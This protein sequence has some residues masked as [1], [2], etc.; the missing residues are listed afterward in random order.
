MKPVHIVIIGGGSR[1]AGYAEF[2]SRN[3]DLSESALQVME[4]I[5]EKK[6]NPPHIYDI[7]KHLSFRF[8]GISSVIR[9]STIEALKGMFDSLRNVF[10]DEGDTRAFNATS[11]NILGTL[12][13]ILLSH[14]MQSSCCY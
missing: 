10:E 7:Y 14:Y 12:E 9:P 2:A 8:G 4:D 5:S 3:P 6:I 1:G 13:T 11:Q